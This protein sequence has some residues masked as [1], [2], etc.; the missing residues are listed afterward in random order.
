M[1]ADRRKLTIFS[2]RAAAAALALLLGWLGPVLSL[3]ASESEVCMMECCV[4]EGHC[5]CAARKPWVAGQK[6]DGVP[7]VAQ[8]DGHLQWPSGRMAGGDDQNSYL[9]SYERAIQLGVS[10]KK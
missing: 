6:P 3:A 10:G 7:A 8:S 5:C 1:N 2:L 4:A 9:A